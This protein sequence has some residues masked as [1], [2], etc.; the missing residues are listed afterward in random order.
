MLTIKKIL[1]EFCRR[2]GYSLN[3]PIALDAAR[4]LIGCITDQPIDE[5]R[6]TIAL[7]N[8]VATRRTSSGAIAA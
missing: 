4:M 6:L 1:D 8:W 5:K 3:H 7:E 2:H